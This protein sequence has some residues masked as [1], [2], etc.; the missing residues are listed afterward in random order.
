LRHPTKAVKWWQSELPAKGRLFFILCFFVKFYF[1]LLFDIVIYYFGLWG[2]KQH[3]IRH[4]LLDKIPLLV[5]VCGVS[6]RVC[7]VVRCVGWGVG[8]G[9]VV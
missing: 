3:T 2:K 8:C 5:M 6:V 9:C 4:T 7:G 1:I